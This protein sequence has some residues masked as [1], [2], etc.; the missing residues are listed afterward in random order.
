M[1]IV[2]QDY[3]LNNLL[4]INSPIFANIDLINHP[5]SD[6]QIGC[7]VTQELQITNY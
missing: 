7:H 5:I 2:T 1:T 3:N 4:R 6:I